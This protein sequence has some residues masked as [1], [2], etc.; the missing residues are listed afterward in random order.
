MASKP[1]LSRRDFLQVASVGA[2]GMALAA[3]VQPGAPVASDAGGDTAA[4]EKTSLR[5]AHWWGDAFDEAI[6]L[7]ADYH[8]RRHSR[9][10]LFPGCWLLY[11][12]V[13]SRHRR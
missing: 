1:T 4:M 3:C 8:R 10:R 7:F 6:G 13:P 11:G 2:A 5:V 12:S 9:G